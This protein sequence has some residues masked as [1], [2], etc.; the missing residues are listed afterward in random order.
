MLKKIIDTLL[1]PFRKYQEK[2]NLEK[3]LKA[4]R[5][6]DPFIYK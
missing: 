3:R 5:E 4:L 6:K 2:K 1:Y